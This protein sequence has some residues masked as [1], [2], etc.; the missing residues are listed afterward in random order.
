MRLWLGEKGRRLWWLLRSYQMYMRS[1]DTKEMTART[2]P[3]LLTVAGGDRARTR[4]WLYRQRTPRED[5]REQDEG[6]GPLQTHWP[7]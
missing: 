6:L 1:S 4:H 2:L 7:S 3:F 5:S